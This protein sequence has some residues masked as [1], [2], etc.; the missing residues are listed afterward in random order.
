MAS[1]GD[2]LPGG[3]TARHPTED[4][5][6]QVLSVLDQ[7]WGG[8]GGT[9]GAAQRALLLPRL[10]FQHFTDSS[11]LVEDADGALR[12]FLVGFLSPA[13]P[14]VAYIHFA[15]VDPA[16]QGAGIGAA[17]YRRFLAH[18][19]SRGA[20][21]AACITSP[22]NTAS[23]AFHTRLGFT[24]QPGDALLDGVPVHRDYDG[25]GLHRVV[26]TRPLTG[27]AASGPA[28]P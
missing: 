2:D 18:G 16:L 17:L 10:F 25:P 14:N 4:D 12:A 23:L 3:L 11:W 21:T 22:G 7:W 27:D 28:S 15:G 19:V 5:H 13:R 24:I 1:V 26:F 20:H 6:A 9:E 8:F